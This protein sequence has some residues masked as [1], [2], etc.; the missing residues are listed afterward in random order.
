M[1]VGLAETAAVLVEESPVEG[2]QLN[3]AAPLAVSVTLLPVK[4]VAE[5]G[6]TAIVGNGFT[7]TVTVDVLSHPAPFVPVTR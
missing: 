6:L 7:V 1:V 4:I 2:V 3:V 5:L